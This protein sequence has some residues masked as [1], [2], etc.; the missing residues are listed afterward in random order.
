M[1]AET[2]EH[3]LTEP[4]LWVQV[5][6][7]RSRTEGKAALF[8]DRDGVINEDSGY[9][10]APDEIVLR[11]QLTPVLQAA[12]R[13]GVPVIIVTNQSGIARGYFDW[14]AFADV[15]AYILQALEARGGRIAMV[16]ACAYHEAGQVP[17]A[18][19]DHPMRKPNPGMCLE[20]GKRL[21]LDL[22]RSRIIGDKV[23]DLQAGMRAGLAGG[24]LIGEGQVPDL[25]SF[26]VRM[27]APD[28]GMDDVC[29]AVQV[30]GSGG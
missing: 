11:D 20:A 5:L 18:V 7:A 30:M 1:S 3:H 4:G 13:A 29:R 16:L 8:L 9:P 17:F 15:N 27:V 26:E 23:S 22:A 25:P 6:A 12:A 14:R 28:G 19:A 24:W 2:F 21:G 10:A